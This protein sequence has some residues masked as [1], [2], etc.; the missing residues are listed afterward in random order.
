VK[1]MLKNHRLALSLSDAAFG[2][3]EELLK[4]KAEASG[5]VVVQVDPFFPSTRCC[6]R[7]THERDID[8]SER[9]YVCLNPKCR[10]VFDRDYNASMNILH[11]GKRL[12]GTA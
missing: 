3:F 11:E 2:R 12:A 9:T 7:C 4:Q 8:L 6:H 10:C 5:T 1:G